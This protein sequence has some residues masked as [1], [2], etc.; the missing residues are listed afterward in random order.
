ME[1][2]EVPQ[3]SGSK[4]SPRCA[5]RFVACIMGEI[6]LRKN[7]SGLLHG[8][9]GE[10]LFQF[11]TSLFGLSREPICEPPPQAP[12]RGLE[13]PLPAPP[14][15]AGTGAGDRAEAGRLCAC[16]KVES[17]P[18]QTRSTQGNQAQNNSL[19]KKTGTGRRLNPVRPP[20]LSQ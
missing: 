4:R 7:S 6:F 3:H 11:Q 12:F 2:P 14:L 20:P 13:R 9:S 10:S 18:M 17:T 19:S 5:D 1:V 8:T 15:G 16:V